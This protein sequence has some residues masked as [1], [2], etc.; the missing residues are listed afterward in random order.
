M[1]FDV[2]ITETHQR[3]VTIEADT[4]G[5]AKEIAEDRWNEGYIVLESD[6]FVEVEFSCD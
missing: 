6:D 1:K 5:E 3:V 2:T 4:P